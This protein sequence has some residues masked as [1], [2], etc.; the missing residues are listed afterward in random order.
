[1]KTIIAIE[2]NN[3]LLYGSLKDVAGILRVNPITIG[4]WL[5]NKEADP[6]KLENGYKVYLDTKKI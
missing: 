5:K 4:R 1:M 3:K 2:K 6:I